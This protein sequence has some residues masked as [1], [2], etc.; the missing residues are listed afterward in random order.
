MFFLYFMTGKYS[1]QIWQVIQTGKALPAKQ[2]KKGFYK[3]SKI[4]MTQWDKKVGTNIAN[5]ATYIFDGESL[6]RYLTSFNP[7]F[8]HT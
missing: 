6:K 3:V 2:D 8:L 5:H 4:F 1:R 7:T